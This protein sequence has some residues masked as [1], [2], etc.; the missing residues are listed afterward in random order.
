MYFL[1][2]YLDVFCVAGNNN[3][4]NNTRKAEIKGVQATAILGTAHTHNGK[5]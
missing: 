2:K 1:K 3:N 5:C 4:N